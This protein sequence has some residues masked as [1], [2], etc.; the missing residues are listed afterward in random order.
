MNRLQAKL[1]IQGTCLVAKIGPDLLGFT[2]AAVWCPSPSRQHRIK[3]YR[4]PKTLRIGTRGNFEVAA[5]FSPP[6]F[7]VMV[8]RARQRRLICVK[9]DG[10]WHQW[11]FVDFVAT[12][13]GI[14]VRIDLE[15]HTP[16]RRARQHV[17]VFVLPA[18]ADRPPMESL[19]DCLRQLYP[20]ASRPASSRNPSW[21]YRPIYCGWGDQVGLSLDLEGPG[22]ESRAVAYCTQ[23]LYERW[24][25]RLEDAGVPIGTITVD[26]GWSSGGVWQPRPDQWPD[27]RGFVDRQHKKGRRVLL[28][29]GTWLCEG[30]PDD[31][32]ISAG[33]TTL[34]A[35]PTNPKYR[36]FLRDQVRR[37]LAPHAGCFN[38]DGFKIDQLGYTPSENQPRGALHFGRMFEVPARHERLR[39]AGTKWGCELL[40]QLQKDIYTAAKS[41][42]PDAL[43]TSSTVHP[44]F[45][46]TFDMVRLHDTGPVDT[47]VF[48][49]MKVRADL[50][51][52]AL[53]GKPIDTD[54]WVHTDYQK[55][56]DY[57]LQSHRLG[58]PCL[59]YTERFVRSFETATTGAKHV[60]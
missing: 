45:H 58:V 41:A 34:V 39:L 25:R 5:R 14:Q 51:A 33:R 26:V 27:L 13:R 3:P 35:D 18:D 21:W 47:D 4:V 59:F 12:G 57:T 49:A 36:R 52:A 54:D 19:A 23:G 38:A 20:A 28:W 46:D 32:C 16:A 15:G 29:I 48:Q 22:R 8:Q 6:P 30:L 43:I 40:H 60:R 7:A 17:R 53:P 42:K 10:G 9:A 37:L 31:R 2:P 24:V 55:W 11:S 56:L 44:Y 1:T 50:A